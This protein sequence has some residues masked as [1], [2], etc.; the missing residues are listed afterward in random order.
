MSNIDKDTKKAL[1]G[2]VQKHGATEMK[3]ALDMLLN[4]DGGE[5]T[6]EEKDKA[7]NL[8]DRLDGWMDGMGPDLGIERKGNEIHVTLPLPRPQQEVLV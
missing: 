2:Q 8:K 7:L 5:V 3:R 1:I 6:P 4:V